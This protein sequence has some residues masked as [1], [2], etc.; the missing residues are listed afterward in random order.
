ML[1]VGSDYRS[2]IRSINRSFTFSV[3]VNSNTLDGSKFK[4]IKITETGVSTK[5]LTPGEFSK[6]S[7]E[8]VATSDNGE[9]WEDSTFKVYLSVAGYA[10][11]IPMGKFWVNT[12]K[13]QDNGYAYKI[14]AYSRDPWWDEQY[15]A[16]NG[17]TLVSDILDYMETQ[18]GSTIGGSSMITLEEITAVPA[19]VTNAQM[20][21]ML[22]GFNGFSVRTSRDGDPELFR[23]TPLQYRVLVPQTTLYP[24]TTLY[25]GSTGEG[26]SLVTYST[27]LRNI[28][29]SGLSIEKDTTIG[30]YAVTNTESTLTVGSGYGVE[31]N[32]PWVT[33]IS[34]VYDLALYLNET[35]TPMTVK[36]RGDPALEIGD[37]I[38]VNGKLCYIMEQTF[39]LDGGL[40]HT[41]KSYSGES[42]QMV[43][44]STTL[45]RKIRNIYS[46]MLK[47][48]QQVFA[49]IFSAGNGYFSFIDAE[50]EP[51]DVDDIING[52]VP[53]GFRISDEP[54]VTP[55]TK[56]WEFV[57]GG[58]YSSD[59]GFRTPGKLAL[60]QDG[61]IVGDRILANS[62]STEQLT[63]AVRGI[64]DNVRMNFDFENDGLH[65][66]R[67]DD[68]GN[69]V[70]GYQY[71]SIFNN[72]GFRV[73]DLTSEFASLVAEGDTV[74]ANN[75]TADQYL[76]V[77]AVNVSA[78][79][80]Q[81]YSSVFSEPE[82]GIFQEVV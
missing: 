66:A 79:F 60:T 19:D 36:W 45:D 78:R 42:S 3:V 32:N 75:L 10:T 58:L 2:A 76:R 27:D 55:T 17:L 23:Y 43:L 41:I 52:A 48:I 54:E 57:L 5:K 69:Y 68:D 77:R 9:D 61:Y 31:Y 81:F 67:K 71:E 51:L 53:A 70:E 35:Y 6:N 7:C 12:I 59:D 82:F 39:E 73:M 29:E 18:S 4:S 49:G 40:R 38:Q 30:S 80:Q 44:G 46:G 62:I 24:S 22:A 28:F 50:R 25:P 11:P 26:S 33:E 21:G 72:M 63:V 34:Q 15:D 8:L 16:D 56:G 74:T 20:L 64:I 1:T 47:E 13:E 65:I 14:T 37:V